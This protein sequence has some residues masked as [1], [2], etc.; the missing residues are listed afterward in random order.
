MDRRFFRSRYDAAQTIELFGARLRDEVD[1]AALSADLQ[2]V[3]V[4]T[5]R[6]AHVSLWLRTPGASDMSAARRS[7]LAWASWPLARHR[8]PPPSS[9]SVDGDRL[10][11]ERDAFIW[12]ITLVFLVAGHVI[13]TRQPAQPDRL[14]VPRR[15]CLRGPGA[16]SSGAYGDY[17]LDTGEGSRA[18]GQAA[19]VYGEISWVPF[20]L[21]PATFLLLLFPDG[22]LLSS[23]WRP[24]AWCAVVGIAG[25]VVGHGPQAR[26]ARG[27][28]RLHEPARRRE[29]A[30]RRPLEGP[31]YLALLIGLVGSAAS[32]VLRFRRARGEQR[33]QMKWIALAG[34]LAAVAIPSTFVFYEVVG[35]DRRRRRDHA[36][37][38]GLCRRRPPSRSCATGSTTSTS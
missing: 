29:R 16:G 25:V 17:W 3:V 7:A 12:A 21:V 36:Q 15:W 8:S 30:A 32:L 11:V 14:D 19:A 5:M 10:D 4:E 1:L 24:V 22:R 33:E 6:P 27:L 28:S 13:A 35:Q 9:R 2:A 18:L 38:P 20:V 31:A 34:A 37:H 23:R 26:P